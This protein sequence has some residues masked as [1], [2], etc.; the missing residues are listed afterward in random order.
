M[1]VLPWFNRSFIWLLQDPI[2]PGI[3]PDVPK[4]AGNGEDPGLSAK[5]KDVFR[6]SVLDGE[7]GRRDRWRDDE[8][9]PNSAQRWTRWRE[10][11]KEHGDTRKVERWSDDPSKFSVDGRRTPQE[12]WGDSN[13][14]E[15]NHDQRREKWSTRWGSNDKESESRRDRWGDSGKEG[16]PSREKSFSHYAPYGKDGNSHE[17]DT[18]RDGNMSR[19]WKSGY[20]VGRGRGDSSHYPSQTPQKSSATYGYGRGKPDNEIS[21]LQSSHAK[22]TSS[23]GAIS[24]GSPRPFHLGL[25]SDRPG[26]MSGDRSAFRYSR[27]K[28]LDICRTCDLTSFKIPVDGFEEV[29]VFM[30]DEA[31]EPLA[32]SAPVAEEA[33][34]MLFLF[35]SK[36]ILLSYYYNVHISQL[37]CIC[38]LF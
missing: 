3:C 14:K 17:K 7:T 32:L 12:R 16:D 38:R 13:N 28:L 20:P 21:N 23:T 22:F 27:M 30:Q 37:N 2:S 34:T 1:L 10:T 5:K 8:R 4:A 9:E 25:L 18:E 33:V 26:G 15:G 11:D 29:S 6:A 35:S 31:L 19:S 36:K 24:S